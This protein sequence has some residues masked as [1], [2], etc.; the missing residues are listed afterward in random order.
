MYNET[1]VP[2]E[3]LFLLVPLCCVT[4]LLKQ[5]WDSWVSTLK[6]E[7]TLMWSGKGRVFLFSR[8]PP[9]PLAHKKQKQNQNKK[10]NH[11]GCSSRE[12]KTNKTDWLSVRSSKHPSMKIKWA[13][14]ELIDCEA[15]FSL[16]A[17]LVVIWRTSSAACNKAE[18]HGFPRG[19][20][21]SQYRSMK[22]RE[23][24]WDRQM[25]QAQSFLRER[26][27]LYF[28]FVTTF[29]ELYSAKLLGGWSELFSRK[30]NVQG[31]CPDSKCLKAVLNYQI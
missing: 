21:K 13:K 7:D 11:H 4:A 26:E 5:D 27:K 16:S 9:F 3:L 25:G 12:V 18:V 10:K 19:E 30:E 24:G 29:W 31:T 14:Q 15:L 2:E 23:R 17:P 8:A 22:Q 28:L 1:Q 20:Y 6:H